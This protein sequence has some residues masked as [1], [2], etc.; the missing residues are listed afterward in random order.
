MTG[1]S[2]AR[3]SA[4][5]LCGSSGTELRG[6]CLQGLWLNDSDTARASYSKARAGKPPAIKGSTGSSHGGGGAAAGS[7]TVRVPHRR[8]LSRVYAARMWQAR[9]RQYVRRKLLNSEDEAIMNAAL[10]S[11]ISGEPRFGR[12]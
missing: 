6:A 11:D 2:G 12:E 7:A 9:W 1:S 3:L 4:R 10:M 5:E 8:E